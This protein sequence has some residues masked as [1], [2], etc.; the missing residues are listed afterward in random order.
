MLLRQKFYISKNQER[1]SYWDLSM[2]GC[3]TFRADAPDEQLP[4]APEDSNDVRP[5]FLFFGV[6]MHFASLL[7]IFTGQGTGLFL[8]S[9]QSLG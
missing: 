9:G 5:A 1:L 2:F 6:Q 4:E 8:F 7:I 3:L